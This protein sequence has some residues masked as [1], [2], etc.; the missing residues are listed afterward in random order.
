MMLFKFK[1]K[2]KYIY[3]ISRF[4]PETEQQILLVWSS[5]SG[6]VSK[7]FWHRIKNNIT[8]NEWGTIVKTL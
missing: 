1:I 5:P 4:A 7:K 6:Y 2:N 8:I 3:L